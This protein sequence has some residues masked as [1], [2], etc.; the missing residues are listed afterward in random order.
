MATKAEI[1]ADPNSAFNRAAD[2]E[3]LFVLR[4][5]DLAAPLAVRDWLDLRQK[6]IRHGVRPVSDYPEIQTAAEVAAAMH[7]WKEK[8]N[9]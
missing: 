1:L 4:A 7:D 8:E 5:H 6:M 3:P 2:D 9:S